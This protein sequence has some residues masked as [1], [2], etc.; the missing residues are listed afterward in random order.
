MHPV[1]SLRVCKDI[2]NKS[3]RWNL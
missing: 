3:K 2:F 1:V